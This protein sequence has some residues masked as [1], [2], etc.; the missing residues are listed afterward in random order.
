MVAPLRKSVQQKCRKIVKGR[1]TAVMMLASQRD[2]R[3][4]KRHKIAYFATQQPPRAMKR[5]GIMVYEFV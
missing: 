4:A 5:V 1:F 3:D 2:V